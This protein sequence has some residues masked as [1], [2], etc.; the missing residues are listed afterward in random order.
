MGAARFDSILIPGLGA[1]E[2]LYYDD[3]WA[4]RF[5]ELAHEEFGERVIATAALCQVAR[6][7]IHAIP[8]VAR[9]LAGIDK[10]PQ[11]PELAGEANVRRDDLA[12]RIATGQ[13]PE[14]VRLNCALRLIDNG[15][16]DI[17][18]VQLRSEVGRYSPALKSRLETH[19]AN[20]REA[21]GEEPSPRRAEGSLP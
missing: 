9:N 7:V 11:R 21:G 1:H 15:A 12:V 20:V 2:R 6:R 4:A 5:D 17:G 8:H 19:G 14:M 10:P 3:E 13:R 16:D 18:G